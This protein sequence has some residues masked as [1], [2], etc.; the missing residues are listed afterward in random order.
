MLISS[1]EN[2]SIP[3]TDPYSANVGDAAAAD[4]IVNEFYGYNPANN[5]NCGTGMPFGTCA[6][7]TQLDKTV[8]KEGIPKSKT[9][10]G[11][12]TCCGAAQAAYQNFSSTSGTVDTSGSVTSLPLATALSACVAGG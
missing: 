10:I 1:E 5:W 2:Q 9:L 7:I 4:S 8:I 3:T 12:A 11:M 6:F